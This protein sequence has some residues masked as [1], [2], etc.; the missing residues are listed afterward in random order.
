MNHPHHVMRIGILS[1][2]LAI[3]MPGPV[4]H[5]APLPAPKRMTLR[6]RRS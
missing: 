4:G 2:G 6:H 5:A 3:F 1:L